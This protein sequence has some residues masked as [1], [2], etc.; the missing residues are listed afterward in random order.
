MQ[1]E[2]P[3]TTVTASRPVDPAAVSA[4]HALIVPT[5]TT[6]ETTAEPDAGPVA[7]PGAVPVRLPPSYCPVTGITPQWPAGT[8]RRRSG[9]E[10]GGQRL[11]ARSGGAAGAEAGA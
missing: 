11:R 10:R 5:P 1:N 2:E 6:S 7:G 9:P 8:L 3:S 4:F